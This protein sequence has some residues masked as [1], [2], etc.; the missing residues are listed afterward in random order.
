MTNAKKTPNDDLLRQ[1]RRLQKQLEERGSAGNGERQDTQS[2]TEADSPLLRE[3]RRLKETTE[4]ITRE[5]NEALAN[6][7]GARLGRD[8]GIIADTIRTITAGI[9]WIKDKFID[10]VCE[11]PY[12]GPSLKWIGKTVYAGYHNFTHPYPDET[13]IQSV[14]KALVTGVKKSGNFCMNLFRSEEVPY[15]A[16]SRQRGMLSKSRAG[17]ASLMTAWALSAVLSV[18]YAGPS[19]NYFVSEPLVDGSRMAATVVFNAASGKGFHLNHGDLHY[20]IPTKEPG[21]E[22]YHVSASTD[23]NSTE[24]NSYSFYARDRLANE[25][26]SW[27]NGHGPFNPELVVAPIRTD[28]NKCESVWYGALWKAPFA[29]RIRGKPELLQVHCSASQ[30]ASGNPV[31]HTPPV[32]AP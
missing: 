30:N 23:E 31:G 11:S 26:W 2:K 8:I 24:D 32:P 12:V 29:K 25:V 4:T 15:T 28:A 14:G 6:S 1:A 18:P 21:D 20:G 9:G 7:T 17:T 16:P 5:A 13:M 3:A 27:V 10:P 22:S 19:F